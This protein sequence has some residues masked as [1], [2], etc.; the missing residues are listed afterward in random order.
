MK[1]LFLTTALFFVFVGIGFVQK[2]TGQN[3]D[4]ETAIS[5]LEQENSR[6]V[7]AGDKASYERLYADDF[8]GVNASGGK[9]TKQQMVDFYTSGTPVIA[10]HETDQTSIRIFDKTAVVTARLKYKYSER[11]ADPRIQWLRYTR[12]YVLREDRWLIVAEHFCF[13]SEDE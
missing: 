4:F 5:K 9:S 1:N 11:V 6:A 13:I 2:T 3:A 10:V 7:I 12:I 8:V